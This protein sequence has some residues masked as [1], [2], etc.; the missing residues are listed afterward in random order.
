M[1]ID[2]LKSL[3][4]LLSRLAALPALE[5]YRTYLGAA[6][7]GVAAVAAFAIAANSLWADG[8][9][10]KTALLAVG[11]VYLAGSAV[12]TLGLGKK[13]DDALGTDLF[14][15]ETGEPVAVIDQDWLDRELAD[16]TAEHVPPTPVPAPE[17][18]M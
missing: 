18:T 8:L 7:K 12:G 17:D 9:T 10:E 16:R 1:K 5:G 2:R 6:A 14:D 4:A 13:V 3:A 15:D 11:G